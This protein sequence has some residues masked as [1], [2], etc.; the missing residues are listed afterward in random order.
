[1]KVPG[2]IKEVVWSLYPPRY[3]QL[4]NKKFSQSLGYMSRMLLIAFVIA[5]LILLPKFAMMKD[6]IQDG[7]GLT[8]DETRARYREAAA[9]QGLPPDTVAAQVV[10]ALS[11]P[12]GVNLVETSVRNYILSMKG[13]DAVDDF[14]ERQNAIM[15]GE[16]I[17]ER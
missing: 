4:A 2:F 3:R 12:P 5:G 11:Q 16:R 13:Y 7:Y 14:A 15:R 8:D 10:N 6:Q 17:P 1:M 9:T